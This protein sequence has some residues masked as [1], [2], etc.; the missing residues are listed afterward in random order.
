[1]AN[2]KTFPCKGCPNR[3]EGCHGYCSEYK[4]AKAKYDK[5]K[6]EK[7][8]FADVDDFIIRST[9]KHANSSKRIWR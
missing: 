6:E 5:A 9:I 2:N 7:N 3:A 8:R 1:M 4:R